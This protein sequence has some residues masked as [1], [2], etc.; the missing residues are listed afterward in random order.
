MVLLMLL[1]ISLFFLFCFS[2][3]FSLQMEVSG[4][5]RALKRRAIDA[6]HLKNR[7]A[8][9]KKIVQQEMTRMIKHL[10]EQ[11]ASTQASMSDHNHPGV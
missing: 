10:Q 4:A 5:S 11:Q 8:E 1:C 9:E 7:A 6:L 2:Q 3:L